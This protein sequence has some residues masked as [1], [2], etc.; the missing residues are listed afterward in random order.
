MFC[1]ITY[2]GGLR[3]SCVAN[4]GVMS[5]DNMNT[6]KE[7]VQTEFDDIISFMG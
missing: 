2:K 3:V 7:C 5:A 4:S 6:L 1:A